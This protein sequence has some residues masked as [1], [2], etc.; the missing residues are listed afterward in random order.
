[1]NRIGTI[2]DLSHVT[3]DVMRQALTQSLAPCM[4]SHSSVYNLSRVDRNVP[5]DV[6]FMVRDT[7]SVV[8]INF[9]CGFIT[10]DGQPDIDDVADHFDYIRDLIGVDYVGI[11]ADYD[12]I[13]CLPTGLEDVSTYPYIIAELLERNYSDD[14]IRKIMGGNILRVMREVENVARNLQSTTKSSEQWMELTNTCRSPN[15]NQ[16]D[17]KDYEAVFV[18]AVN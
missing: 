12:G 4:F 8:M 10:P 18:P 7:N 9:A 16:A 13:E 2:V 1:M 14:D 17:D 5:D 6:L 3:S 11:G 15:I